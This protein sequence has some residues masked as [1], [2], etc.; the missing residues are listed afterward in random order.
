MKEDYYD[1]KAQEFYD[2]SV[3]ANVSELYKPFLASIPVR[4]RI[5]DAG[6]GSGR[7][8]K[9][10]FEMGYDVDAID[11][12]AEMTRMATLFSGVAV[13][14]KRFEELNAL[15]VYDGIWACASLLHVQRSNLVEV[16]SKVGLALKQSGCLYASFKYGDGEREEDGR[17]FTDMDERGLDSVLSEIETLSLVSAWVTRDV[18]SSRNQSW[19]NIVCGRIESR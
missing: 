10:F 13:E 19:L 7:D 8:T 2:N 16:L 4:G 15:D 3:G 12:S 1:I 5:L 14:H 11:A 17:T 9:A 6:C 18:R